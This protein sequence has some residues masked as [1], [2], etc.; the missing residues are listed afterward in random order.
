[1]KVLL[2]QDIRGLGRK[3]EIKEISDGYARN[4]LFPKKLATIADEKGQK[5]KSEHDEKIAE[6]LVML[7]AAIALLGKESFEF[8]VRGGKH[9]EVFGSV[10]K[11]D[12]EEQLHKKGFTK[13][14][15]LLIH[16][17]KATGEH[18][19]EVNFGQGIHGKVK[20]N[21]KSA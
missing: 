16:P 18:E 5:A 1:M 11:K 13:C 3:F 4:F 10:S 7:K 9:G 6:Q 8:N 14:E 2:L 15:V 17:I 19:V 12:I 21:I 20:I